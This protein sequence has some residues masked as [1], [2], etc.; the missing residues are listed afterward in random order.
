MPN[1]HKLVHSRGTSWEITYRV[2]GRMAR[3]RFP[4]RSQAV[5]E[6]ARARVDIARGRGLLPVDTKVSVEQYV[7]QWVATLQVRPSTRANYL[8]YVRKYILPAMGRR[9]VS[10]LRRS[11]VAA[12]VAT[13]AGKGLAPTTVAAGY[14]VL[15]MVLRSAVYDK[16]LAT[17]PCY[18]IKLPTRT[19]RTLAAFDTGQIRALLEA[20]PDYDR[21]VLATAVGTGLRQGETLGITMTHLNLLKRELAV[22]LQALT[23]AGGPPHLTGDLKTTASRRLLP[24]PTFVIDELA[25]HLA[26]YGTGQDGLVFPNRH[27]GI[28][29]RGSFNDSVWKP[30]LRRADLPIGYGFHSLRHTYASGLIAENIHPRVIQARLGHKSIVET[31]DTY[32]HLFPDGREETTS[33]LDRLFGA[34]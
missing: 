33:A 29:R 19:G 5:Q 13:M 11:D 34:G 17:S 27:G 28:W 18:K 4:T 32:G 26:T 8:H 10:S 23:P 20:A 12:F 14:H 9:P 21:A 22:E 30:A 31:M 2:E 15:A 7:G 24:L 3:R 25:R 16:V 6:L 1:P